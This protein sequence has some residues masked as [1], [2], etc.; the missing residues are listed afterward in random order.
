MIRSAKLKLLER[1]RVDGGYDQTRFAEIPHRW[2]AAESTDMLLAAGFERVMDYLTLCGFRDRAR[3]VLS[4]RTR[5]LLNDAREYL[6]VSDFVFATMLRSHGRAGDLRDLDGRGLLNMLAGLES[7]G[8]EVSRFIATRQQIT[9]AQLRLLQV[10]RKQVE[11]PDA[12]YYADL[13]TYGGVNS[14]ADLDKRGF[15]LMLILMEASGFD[16]KP[17]TPTAPSLKYGFGRRPGFATPEQIELIRTLWREWSG[18]TAESEAAVEA[19]LNTW[20]ERYHGTSSL[21][22]VTSAGAGKVIT[23]LKTMKARKGEREASH[24]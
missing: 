6:G 22:F 20:L 16:H 7:Y 19:A 9:P 17:A 5:Q 12:R 3:P 1:A 18:P 2:G 4:T 15:D 14:A 21:R 24:A 11:D 23:A 8:L 10:A 13:Q